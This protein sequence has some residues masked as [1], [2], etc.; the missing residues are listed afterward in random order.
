MDHRLTWL[1]FRGWKS[2]LTQGLD[3]P[4]PE[5]QA[6]RKARQQKQTAYYFP[7]ALVPRARSTLSVISI[8]GDA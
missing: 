7:L 5:R 3:P 1:R 4:E 2:P 8:R 6:A